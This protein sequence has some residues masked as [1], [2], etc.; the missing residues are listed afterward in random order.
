MLNKLKVI[1]WVM[2]MLFVAYGVVCYVDILA[3]NL[4]GGSDAQWN[5]LVRMLD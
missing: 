4:S 1:F 2:L 5:F 3:H